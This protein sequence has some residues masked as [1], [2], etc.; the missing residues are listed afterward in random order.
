M[1]SQSKGQLR[2]RVKF[3]TVSTI[4]ASAGVSITSINPF[5][6]GATINLSF[7]LRASS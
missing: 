6:V 3:S 4:C 1:Q 2:A 7:S 5:R